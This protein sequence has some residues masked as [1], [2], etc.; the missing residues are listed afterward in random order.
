[1]HTTR[2][3]NVYIPLSVRSS[4]Y[5]PGCEGLAAQSALSLLSLL[6]GDGVEGD[7]EPSCRQIFMVLS[8][9]HVAIHLQKNH[10]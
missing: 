6:G 5:S 1:M 10:R 7:T 2:I 9:E 8:A 4:R 3:H